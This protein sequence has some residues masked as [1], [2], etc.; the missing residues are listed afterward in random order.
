MRSLFYLCIVFLASSSVFAQ[1]VFDWNSSQLTSKSKSFIETVVQDRCQY[2]M[3]YYKSVKLV[4]EKIEVTRIDQGYKDLNASLEFVMIYQNQGIKKVDRLKI[5]IME[6]LED[7]DGDLNVNLVS[8]EI[9]D[10]W[11]EDPVCR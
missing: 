11:D 8:F 6:E 3:N 5:S 10:G 7:R 4:A 2:Q 1:P 9:L